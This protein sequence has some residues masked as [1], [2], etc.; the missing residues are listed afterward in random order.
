VNQSGVHLLL[1]LSSSQ[2][3]GSSNDEITWTDFLGHLASKRNPYFTLELLPKNDLS[4]KPTG[5]VY[6]R[7][8]ADRDGGTAP[9]FDK[10][11]DVSYLPTTKKTGTLCH[12]DVVRMGFSK[13]TQQHWSHNTGRT[14]VAQH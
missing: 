8:P 7:T 1:L 13:G 3:D 14:L 5:P 12:T 4:S 10:P 6:H 2:A 9:W 11:F